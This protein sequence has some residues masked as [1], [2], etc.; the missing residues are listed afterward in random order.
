[1]FFQCIAMQY[2]NL[3]GL[4]G[5]FWHCFHFLFCKC[6]SPMFSFN[7]IYADTLK[8]KHLKFKKIDKEIANK[9]LRYIM[10]SIFVLLLLAIF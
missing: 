1:M 4:F 3:L 7:T 5:F 10:E 8:R 2:Y 9:Y 6:V